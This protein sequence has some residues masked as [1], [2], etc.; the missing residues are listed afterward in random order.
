MFTD[1]K[2]IALNLGLRGFNRPINQ[3][4]LNGGILVH[5]CPFHKALNSVTTEAADNIVFQGHIKAGAPRVT[6]TAS[7]APELVINSPCLMALG[8]GDMK[9]AKLDYFIVFLL[10]FLEVFIIRITS[11][12]NINASSRHIG[13]NGYCSDLPRLGDDACLLLVVLGIKNLVGDTLPLEQVAE[14]FRFL[15][16]HRANQHRAPLFVKLLNL[17]HYCPE[18][19]LF[20]LVNL[21]R[22]VLTNHSLIGG[23]NYYLKAIYLVELLGFGSGG[24]GHSG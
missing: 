14:V 17:T 3:P 11:Q 7:P 4:V 13:G 18:L 9:P 2:M 6:L 21:V 16:G 20:I 10:P 24:A 15:N 23:D 1:V 8:A 22:V 12:Y 19:S 5:P